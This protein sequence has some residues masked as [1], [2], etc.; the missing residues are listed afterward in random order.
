MHRMTFRSSLWLKQLLAR[1]VTWDYEALLPCSALS[2]HPLAPSQHRPK[3][4][5]RRAEQQAAAA[6]AAAYYK[7]YVIRGFSGSRIFLGRSP[8]IW[9]KS[10]P[11]NCNSHRG[12]LLVG[13]GTAFDFWCGEKSSARWS[14]WL[15]N[16]NRLSFSVCKAK[17]VLVVF[18]SEC[19]IEIRRF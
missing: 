19:D 2:T 13:F 17:Q 15:N 18:K 9:V 12:L 14:G 1:I 3:S 4:L 6:A 10:H 7:Y 16:A 8:Q 11:V 5:L